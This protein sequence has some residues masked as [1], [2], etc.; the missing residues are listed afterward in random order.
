MKNSR[1]RL[2]IPLRIVVRSLPTKRERWKGWCTMKDKCPHCGK[3]VDLDNVGLPWEFAFFDYY[4]DELQELKMPCC[5]N[6]VE[7]CAE[8]KWRFY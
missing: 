2:T 5:G 7:V 4:Y 1:Y 6:V 8:L 3:E